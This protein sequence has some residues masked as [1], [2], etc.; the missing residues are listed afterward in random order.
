MEV[1]PT[2]QLI[3]QFIT[4]KINLHPWFVH[5]KMDG[6]PKYPAIFRHNWVRFKSN[7]S[8]T[9]N[10]FGNQK[11]LETHKKFDACTFKPPFFCGISQPW[12]WHR[13]AGSRLQL[14]RANEVLQH[15]FSAPH[16]G[17]VTTLPLGE[18]MK[19]LTKMLSGIWHQHTI[20]TCM[21]VYICIYVI[22]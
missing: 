21:Y 11:W 15:P 13:N 22:M 9:K 8:Y 7:Y 17:E 3:L 2:W 16:L 18:K 5:P 4:S 19:N 14:L 6:F 12:S 20:S 10:P 1:I